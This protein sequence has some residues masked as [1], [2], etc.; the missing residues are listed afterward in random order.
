MSTYACSSVITATHYATLIFKIK[1]ST[2][3]ECKYQIILAILFIFVD[4]GENSITGD[5][6][7]M[8]SNPLIALVEEE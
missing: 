1:T 3:F 7:A 8:L 6:V 4:A 5:D 2:S